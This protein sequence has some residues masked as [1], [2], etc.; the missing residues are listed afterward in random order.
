MKNAIRWLCAAAAAMAAGAGADASSDIWSAPPA[1]ARGAF[2]WAEH[3]RIGAAVTPLVRLQDGSRSL[4]N[5]FLGTITELTVITPDLPIRPFLEYAALPWF[6]V[7][8]AYE[9]LATRADTAEG[10]TDGEFRLAGPALSLR[11]RYPNESRWTPGASL[12]VI[13]YSAE[14]EADG[15]WGNGF[16]GTPAGRQ[17][18]RDWRASGSPPWPNGGYQRRIEP[19]SQAVGLEM[20]ATLEFRID[21]RWR[22]EAFV[23]HVRADVKAQYTLRVYGAVLEDRGWYEFPHSHTAAGIGVIYQF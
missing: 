3:F 12:G 8:L 10:D 22:V 1:P 6:H 19:E 4:D 15:R 2:D 7:R 11:A 23:R 18:Y 14:F 5:S 13:W 17:A 9:S 16:P 21:E 20:G